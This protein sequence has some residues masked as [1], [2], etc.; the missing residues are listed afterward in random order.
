MKQ[1]FFLFLTATITA[2]SSCSG[3][4]DVEKVA[5]SYGFIH[6]SF[7]F[8]KEAQQK[9]IDKAAE[10]LNAV[11]YNKDAVI[12][13]KELNQLLD[14]ARLAN[15]SR[16][17]MI[18]AAEEMDDDIKYKAK[19]SYYVTLL[20]TLYNNQFKDFIKI[21]DSKSEDRFDRSSQLL[22]APL[23][24]LDKAGKACSEAGEQIRSKY[25]I[26]VVYNPS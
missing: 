12:E 2:F 26:Q 3:T 20:D 18:N 15:Q 16:L 23:K 14:S 13:T 21:L 25:E 11:K 1:A 5:E 17:P 6:S 24:E 8:S 10:A 22:L 7:V 9:F 19:V 4:Q